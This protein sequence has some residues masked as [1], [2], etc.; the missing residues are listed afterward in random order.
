MELSTGR[1]DRVDFRK[2]RRCVLHETTRRRKW[3]EAVRGGIG[4][5]GRGG[6]ACEWE[7]RSASGQR[8]ELIVDAGGDGGESLQMKNGGLAQRRTAERGGH[9]HYQHRRDDGE[10][11]RDQTGRAE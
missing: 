5:V 11:E 1:R 9:G 3:T 7:A 8:A 6:A 4:V 10:Q 2:G